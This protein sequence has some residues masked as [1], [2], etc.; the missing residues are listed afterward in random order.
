MRVMTGR[1]SLALLVFSLA[2]F[3]GADTREGYENSTTRQQIER[4][5]ENTRANANDVPNMPSTGIQGSALEGQLNRLRAE[6]QA[7]QDAKAAAAARKKNELEAWS[8]SYDARMKEI[9]KSRGEHLGREYEQEQLELVKTREGMAA[10]VRS[11]PADQSFS[12]ANY[13]QLIERADMKTELML[14]MVQMAYRD[15]PQAFVLRYGFLQLSTCPSLRSSATASNKSLFPEEEPV[16]AQ[17][18]AQQLAAALPYLDQARQSGDVLDK[19]LACA[20]MAGAYAGLDFSEGNGFQQF[21][22]D[23]MKPRIAAWLDKRLMPCTSTVPPG[24]AL[25]AGLVEPLVRDIELAKSGERLSVTVHYLWPLV[26]RSSWAGVDLNDAKAVRRVYDT[27]RA[28][29][30]AMKL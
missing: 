23:V 25:Y 20:L 29:Y 19:A 11:L 10:Y 24:S 9:K 6:Q 5:D 27:A 15:Y 1:I 7:E 2:G 21:D 22:E 8:A 13:D 16:R 18:K 30:S 26:A 28:R 17:C 4:M 12:V 3:A 14:P